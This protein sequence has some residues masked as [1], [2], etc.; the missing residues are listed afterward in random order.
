[1]FDEQQVGRQQ[2]VNRLL[3][4]RWG[5]AWQQGSKTLQ[6]VQQAFHK[7]P[8]KLKKKKYRI[9]KLTY[10]G[11]NVGDLCLDSFS[12]CPQL[13]LLWFL[14][15]YLIRSSLSASLYTEGIFSWLTINFGFFFIFLGAVEKSINWLRK[16]VKIVK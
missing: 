4:R 13:Y 12:K 16:Y 1:M 8:Q 3:L 7:T 10:Q 6:G 5:R 14:S 15:V 9:I 2:L 11:R